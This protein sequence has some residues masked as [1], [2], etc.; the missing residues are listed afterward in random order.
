MDIRLARACEGKSYSQG[1][2]NLPEFRQALASKFPEYA[3]KI[4]SMYRIDL[5]EFCGNSTRISTAVEKAKASYFRPDS[6][7]DDDQARWCRCIAHVSAK[8]SAY[9]P[10]A[11]CTKSV[12]RVGRF[13]CA[14]YYNYDQMPKEEVEGLAKLKGKSVEQL[15]SSSEAEYQRSPSNPYY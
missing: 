1:G 6:P 5:T 2:L 13:K 14:P 12:G 11:I 15:K 10:Y 4:N 9:N 8:S 7:L 3:Q